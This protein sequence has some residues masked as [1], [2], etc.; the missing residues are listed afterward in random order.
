[1]NEQRRRKKIDIQVLDRA[2]VGM[3]DL[4][5]ELGDAGKGTGLGRGCA[6]RV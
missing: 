6:C 5:T 1:M 3:A 4:P 2:N